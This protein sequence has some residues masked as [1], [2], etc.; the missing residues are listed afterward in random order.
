MVLMPYSQG[1]PA[2]LLNRV[3][4]ACT[5]M[6]LCLSTLVVIVVGRFIDHAPQIGEG[7]PISTRMIPNASELQENRASVLVNHLASAPR[8]SPNHINRFEEIRERANR[9][10]QVR[11]AKRNSVSTAPPGSNGNSTKTQDV[12]SISRSNGVGGRFRDPLLDVRPTEL[13]KA[14][15]STDGNIDYWVLPHGPFFSEP[16][17]VRP[18]GRSLN[19]VYVRNMDDGKNYRLTPSGDWYILPVP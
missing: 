9:D 18:I 14:H 5:L 3:L 12:P 13:A 17:R 4:I 15:R 1:P 7:D 16:A 8:V 10:L 19:G 6:S 11:T 2:A